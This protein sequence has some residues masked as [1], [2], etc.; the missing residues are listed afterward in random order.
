MIKLNAIRLARLRAGMET[1]ISG[2]ASILRKPL[3]LTGWY[4]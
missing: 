1:T 2:I 4:C 3:K